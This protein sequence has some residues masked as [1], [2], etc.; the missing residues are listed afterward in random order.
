MSQ[1]NAMMDAIEAAN[2]AALSRMRQFRHDVEQGL[3][4]FEEIPVLKQ[5]H[6]F[7]GMVPIRAGGHDLV[8]FHAHDDV[9]VW[10]YLWRGADGY[11]PDMVAQWCNWCRAASGEV[12]DIGAYSGLMS[13]LAALS[14]PKNMVHLF[15]PLARVVER[16]NVNVKLNGLQ[17]RIARHSVAC[18][19]RTGMAEMILYRDENFLGTG[20]S[21]EAKGTLKQFGKQ[22]IRTVALDE[23]LPNARPRVVKID[24]EGHELATLRGMRRT[25]ER[26]K[27]HMLVEVWASTRDEVLTLLADLGYRLQRVESRDLPVNNFIAD[28]AA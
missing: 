5:K 22:A 1:A 9:V 21:I 12:W 14:H 27:P 15:E 20:S 18:S 11:E 10:E 16:A 26:A 19:D 13:I 17:S 2:S 24:V 3:A 25:L 6:P 28:P 4:S 7:R 8:M 23:L